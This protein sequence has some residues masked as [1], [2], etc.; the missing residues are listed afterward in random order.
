M[1]IAIETKNMNLRIGGLLALL[2]ALLVCVPVG[3]Q[4]TVE[5]GLGEADVVLQGDAGDATGGKLA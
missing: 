4:T 3:A 1:M 5:L 2:L